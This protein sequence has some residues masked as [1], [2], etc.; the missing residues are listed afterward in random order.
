MSN[1]IDLQLPI[2]PG[3]FIGLVAVV[4]GIIAFTVWPTLY[5]YDRIQLQ[6]TI[7]PVR[8]HRLTGKTEILQG[9]TGWQQVGANRS[10]TSPLK[11]V[12]P[13]DLAKIDGTLSLTDYGWIEAHLYNGTSKKLDTVT[14]EVTLYNSDGGVQLSR[15]Y[16]L[17]PTG[18]DPLQSSKFIVE[19]GI[20]FQKGQRFEWRMVSADYE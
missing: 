5:R 2:R 16:K 19:S 13:S 4:L 7:F 3:V 14:V 1:R 17:G 11:N 20:Y 15:Q 6:G 18:G 8:I 10:E 9:F 12:S